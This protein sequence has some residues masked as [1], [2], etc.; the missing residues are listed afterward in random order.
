MDV[1]R[2]I[3]GENQAQRRDVDQRMLK[4]KAPRP[5]QEYN[6]EEVVEA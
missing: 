1:L 4:M 3:P 6:A 2:A 5:C